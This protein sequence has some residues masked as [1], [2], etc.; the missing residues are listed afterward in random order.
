MV[1]EYGGK[2][3]KERKKKKSEGAEPKRQKHS[4]FILRPL[5]DTAPTPPNLQLNYEVHGMARVRARLGDNGGYCVSR[6]RK[7][8]PPEV[9]EKSESSIRMLETLWVG[10]RTVTG[11]GSGI[12]A[13]F[14][15]I[16]E[17]QE[18]SAGICLGYLRNQGEL[19]CIYLHAF[20]PAANEI[21]KEKHIC[22]ILCAYNQ[23][24]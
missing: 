1:T 12:R 15:H 5:L 8:E 18:A 9:R 4:L 16:S 13:K 24:N 10:L 11:S 7:M 17:G 3:K 20:D 22:V 19:L 14:S 2:S 21:H 23:N 6:F